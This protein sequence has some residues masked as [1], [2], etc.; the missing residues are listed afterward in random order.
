[1]PLDITNINDWENKTV[2]VF[3]RLELDGV[4]FAYAKQDNAPALESSGLNT[5]KTIRLYGDSV[6]YVEETTNDGCKYTIPVVQC[7]SLR[8]FV[9]RNRKNANS[10]T[11][12]LSYDN[13][14]YVEQ[15]SNAQ[16]V[17]VPTGN[18]GD[19]VMLTIIGTQFTSDKTS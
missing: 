17:D 2:D 10:F 3:P 19:V 13:E 11:M 5:I 9:L 14:G 16:F 15:V 12:R 7:A 4:Q 6:M 8:N 18:N 1:M